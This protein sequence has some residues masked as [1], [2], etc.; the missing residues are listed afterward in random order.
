METLVGAKDAD[1][2]ETTKGGLVS[3]PFARVWLGWD[4]QLPL[5]QPPPPVHVLVTVPPFFR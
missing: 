4:Y 1:G 5:L 2:P 3:P